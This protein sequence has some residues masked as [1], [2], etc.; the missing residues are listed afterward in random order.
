MIGYSV[1]VPTIGRPELLALLADLHHARGPRPAKVIVVD[2]RPGPVDPLPVEHFDG[3]RVVRSGGR[4]PAAA[5]NAGW[6]EAR[7]EWVAFLDDDV[8]VP[9]DWPA[10]LQDDLAGLPREVGASQA[11]LVVPLPADRRPTDDERGTAGLASARWITADMAYRRAVLAEVGG[12]D[13]RFP[14]AYR[15]D[16]DL[17]L[18]V[19]EAGYL[20]ERG[21]RVTTHPARRSAPLASLRAQKGNAD[22]ALMRRKHGPDWRSRVG[23][24]RG[25]LRQHALATATAVGSVALAAAGRRRAALACAAGWAGLTA[26]FAGRRISAGPVTVEEVTRMLVTSVLIPPAACAHRLAGELRHRGVRP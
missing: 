9:E 13:E 21:R 16:V 25:R 7:S 22:N 3:V 1:V 6:R 4:G 19:T 24:G 8:R 18:R 23:E 17:A 20:I 26:E 10:R 12:F 2:D 14:R 11:R 15:E 5:R